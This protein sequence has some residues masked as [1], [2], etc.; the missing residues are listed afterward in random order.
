MILVFPDTVKPL[1]R[2]MFGD[3]RSLG[4]ERERKGKKGK[5]GER[6]KERKKKKRGRNR[7]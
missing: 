7:G 3:L 4:K 1:F 5:E 2:R 6:K